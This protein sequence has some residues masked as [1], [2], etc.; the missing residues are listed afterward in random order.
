MGEGGSSAQQATVPCRRPVGLPRPSRGHCG[1]RLREVRVLMG[2]CSPSQR[3]LPFCPWLLLSP[4]LC[5]EPTISQVRTEAQSRVMPGAAGSGRVRGLGFLPSFHPSAHPRFPPSIYPPFPLFHPPTHPSVRPSTYPH[6]LPS[7]P[8]AV[9]PLSPL[10]SCPA[11]PPALRSNSPPEP[12]ESL[13][14]GTR[15]R[16]CRPDLP[17][18]RETTNE[19]WKQNVLETQAEPSTR[20]GGVGRGPWGR[21]LVAAS[22]LPR[23]A[24]GLRDGAS[25]EGGPGAHGGPGR[26]RRG[27]SHPPLSSGLPRA[28]GGVPWFPRAGSS[29]SW[30]SRRPV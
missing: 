22:P 4:R 1:A 25:W 7:L 29:S 27:L 14:W 26:T 3:Q 20:R 24:L 19:G 16:T 2:P 28:A 18:W 21:L 8:P 12:G 10:P 13:V 9:H 15:S 30:A 6:I 5:G 17:G 11:H 23:V